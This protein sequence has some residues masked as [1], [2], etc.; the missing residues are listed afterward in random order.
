MRRYRDQTRGRANDVAS[1]L[2]RG[3]RLSEH[4]QADLALVESRRRTPLR[5]YDQIPMVGDDLLR[6]VILIAPYLRGR[7]VAFIGDYDGTASLLG[8]MSSRGAVPSPLTM[9]VLDFDGSVLRAV[10]EVARIGQF[11][12]IV[13]LHH[14][15]VFDPLPPGLL[16][17]FDTFYVNP[18]YGASNGGLSAELFVARG[19]ELVIADGSGVVVLPSDHHRPWS[20]DVVSRV[21]GSLADAGWRVVVSMPGIHRYVLDDDPGL[22]SGFFITEA[23]QLT[24][25]EAM[26]L[27]QGRS[28]DDSEIPFFYGRGVSPPYPRLI[29]DRGRVED[30]GQDSGRV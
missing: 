20:L 28:I 5:Q 11:D 19:L 27:W 23:G 1:H 24:R 6:Q 21:Q 16:G 22:M 13:E 25:A 4:D 30:A 8:L 12:D 17:T 15:N 29:L 9:G 14:Y 7:H 18:P 3:I 10:A 26:A 2:V